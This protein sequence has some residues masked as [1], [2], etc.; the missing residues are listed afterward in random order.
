VNVL[1]DTCVWSAALRRRADPETSVVAE[2][3]TLIEDSRVVMA[4]PIRQELLSGIREPDQFARLRAALRPFPDFPLRTE[5][6][7]TAAEFFNRCRRAGIQGSNT[8]FLLCALSVLE[9]MAI[10]TTDRDFTHFARHVPIRLR[11]TEDPRRRSV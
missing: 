3:R 2:L 6:F 9:R 1:V 8:D 7:E 5:H 4:G 11:Y 10:L